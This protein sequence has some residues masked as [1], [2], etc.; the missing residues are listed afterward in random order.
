MMETGNMN[1]RRP[2]A[3]FV[4]AIL[5]FVF[6]GLGLVCMTCTGI[7]TGFL[8][9]MSE[10]PFGLANPYSGMM[11][12]MKREAPGY[13]PMIWA[14]V[15]LETALAVVLIVSGTGLL[16]MRRWAWWSSVGYALVTIAWQIAYAL[17]TI[18]YVVPAMRLWS[19]H[20]M[21]E[22]QKQNPN[23]PAPPNFGDNPV[24]NSLGPILGAGFWIAYAVAL[25]IVLFLPHVSAAFKAQ[26]A[27]ATSAG[28]TEETWQGERGPEASN[29]NE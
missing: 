19:K 13:V 18:A 16:G 1:P 29:S 8:T 22:L 21:T 2:P 20:M 26:R 6:G 9:Y 25:L 5:N 4:M 12:I 23:S 14:H 15:V 24:L 27:L 17:Y 10:Q 7:G 11:E 28:G 3:V